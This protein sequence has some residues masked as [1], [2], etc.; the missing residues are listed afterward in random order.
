MSQRR[1]RPR[2]R[3]RPAGNAPAPARGID[4]EKLTFKFQGRY[5]RLTDVHG[6]LV[7]AIMA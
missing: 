6:K 5:F 3:P 7:P 1:H 4:H 2:R